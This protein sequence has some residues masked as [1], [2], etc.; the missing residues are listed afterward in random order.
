MRELKYE[1]FGGLNIKGFSTPEGFELETRTRG[2]E[3]MVISLKELN[4]KNLEEYI[5]N[6]NIN[7]SVIRWWQN[8]SD[9][10][11]AAGV[12]YSNI[13]EHYKDYEDYLSNLSKVARL[14]P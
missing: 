5:D 4:K 1:Y 13:V 11:H 10:A 6:F 14:L 9:A 8:G 2:G 3:D 7:D 12:P